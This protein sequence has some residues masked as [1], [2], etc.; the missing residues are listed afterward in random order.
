M[1]KQSHHIRANGG[2]GVVGPLHAGLAVSAQVHSGYPVAGRHEVRREEAIF[3]AEVAHAGR[4]EHQRPRAL[5]V[6]SDLP[7]GNLH[8][9]SVHLDFLLKTILTNYNRL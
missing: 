4:A 1:P 9:V 3:R 8:I 2:D 6:K 7:A 5:I